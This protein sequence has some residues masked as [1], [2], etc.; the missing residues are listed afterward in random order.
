MSVPSSGSGHLYI[1]PL[2]VVFQCRIT[3]WKTAVLFQDFDAILLC[4]FVTRLRVF[5]CTGGS[6][7]KVIV[8]WRWWVQPLLPPPRLFFF[9]SLLAECSSERQEC[10]DPVAA[11]ESKRVR[12]RRGHGAALEKD[13]H[14]TSLAS[15]SH[16][17]VESSVGKKREKK[18]SLAR[19]TATP[20]P[21]F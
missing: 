12:A 15:F 2:R 6:W 7:G 11:E 17:R 21:C 13:P 16:A 18:T 14:S 19:A 10:S 4:R 20:P 1:K 5:G 9:F 3:T 8:M